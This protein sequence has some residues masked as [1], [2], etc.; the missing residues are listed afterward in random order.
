M[1]GLPAADFAS[2]GAGRGPECCKFL[3]AGA[4][5]AECA[6]F[7]S[8]DKHLRERK[9]MKAQRIPIEDYPLCQ[10]FQEKTGAA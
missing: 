8:L 2:C 4:R 7:S 6:R 9:D 3:V 1:S 10:I 5:G